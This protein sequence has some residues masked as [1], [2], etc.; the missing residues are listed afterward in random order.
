MNAADVRRWIAGFEAAAEIDREDL[1]RQRPDPAWAIRL[2]LSIIET[3]RQSAPTGGTSEADRSA[4][5][6]AVRAVWT[7]LRARL[8][9]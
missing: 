3:V 8:T 1:R 2:A 5:D 9:R 4:D 6:E 7:T